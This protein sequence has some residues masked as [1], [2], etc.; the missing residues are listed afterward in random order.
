MN[1]TLLRI[2]HHLPAAARSL[3]ASMRGAYLRAWRYG[4]ETERL[5]EEALARE[6][7]SPEKW[8]T[9]QEERLAQ[10][11]H[12]AATRVPYYRQQWAERRRKGDRASWEYLENW[13]VLGKEPVRRNPRAFIADDCEPRKMLRVQTS[14]T[15]GT[16][17]QLW[18]SRRT[19][20][21]WYALFEARWRRWYGISRHDRW[22]ILGGQLVTPV[23]QQRP[24]FWVWN[25]ALRQLYLSSY[26]LAPDLV[27]DY[28]DALVRYR[29]VY[30]LGY[31]SALFALAYETLRLGRGDVRPRVVITNAEP[32]YDYQREVI[33]RAFQCPVRETYGMAEM[34]AAA[35]ECERGSLHLWPEAG[36]VEVLEGGEPVARGQSGELVCTGLVN[37]DMPLIR[38]RVGDRGT[39]PAEDTGCPCGRLLPTIQSVEGRLDD[40][41]YT[42]DGRRVGRLD[43][44]FKADVPI[45][46][47]QIIQESFTRVRVRF[48]P[49]PEFDAAAA[50]F[51]RQGLR[52]RMGEVEVELEPV[53]QIPRGA[54]GKF[55][56]VVCRV[57]SNE[58]RQLEPGHAQVQ[59]GPGR[60]PA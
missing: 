34:A 57:S 45:K 35:G 1:E 10:V 24:P 14:G 38:Y 46:E 7:W 49:A 55:R 27:A 23:R 3:A 12:R 19:L 56:A 51:I 8:K 59:S 25:S 26:H 21:A 6:S 32:V 33:V 20:R 36:I 54:N 28:L 47:A 48:V 9:W 41:L 50:R 44:V 40:V 4:P 58:L 43:P 52:D 22:A 15:T 60:A 16:P 11:L 17:L 53:A 13:P 31:T 37:L 18:H 29:V 42:R 39:L 2:Y 30:L 5:V